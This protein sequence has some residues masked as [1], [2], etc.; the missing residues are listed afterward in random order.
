[1]CVFILI[2]VIIALGAPRFMPEQQ[3]FIKSGS[4]DAKHPVLRRLLAEDSYRSLE[5]K[6]GSGLRCAVYADTSRIFGKRVAF[7]EGEWESP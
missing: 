5:K 4:P 3:R 2:G 1:M 6:H 7:A